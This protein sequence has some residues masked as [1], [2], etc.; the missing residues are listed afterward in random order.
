MMIAEVVGRVW[1]DRQLPGLTARRLVMV[2]DLSGGATHVAVDLLD[3]GV[4]TTV[5]VA[6]EEAA[7]AACGESLADA[8]IVALV[9]DYD[10]IPKNWG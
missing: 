5:L 4:G 9:S 6:T 8:A 3:A 7:A 1:S 10:P 2:R